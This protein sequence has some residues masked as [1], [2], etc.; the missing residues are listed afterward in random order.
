MG[1]TLAMLSWNAHKTLRNTLNSYRY[2]GLDKLADE[3]IIFFQEISETDRIIANN[4]GYKA[5]GSDQNIGIA[6]AYKELV[7][8]STSDL[9]LFLEN[10]WVLLDKPDDQITEAEEFLSEEWVDVV[11]FRHRQFPGAPLWTLQYKGSELERPEFLLDSIHWTDPGKFVYYE[12]NG[13]D[14]RPIIKIGPFYVTSAIYANWTNNPTMFRRGWL[15]KVILPRLG[16][17]DIEVDIQE[18]WR[19][20][21]QILVAQ[22]EG[23]F[24]HNRI[25]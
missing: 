6:Q 24:T 17:K 10:D 8:K 15:K 2:F 14:W 13:H 25:G 16:N 7:E 3:R 18:W 19:E 23:L 5:I 11:R 12:D 1:F 9:F 21:P 22:G 20:Q 4:F